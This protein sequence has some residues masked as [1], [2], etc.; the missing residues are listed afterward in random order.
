MNVEEQ[1]KFLKELV[2]TLGLS[3][4]E[5]AEKVLPATEKAEEDA[6]KDLLDLIDKG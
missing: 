2:H 5:V 3:N 6:T 1:A 4:R